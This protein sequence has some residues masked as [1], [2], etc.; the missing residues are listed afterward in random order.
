MFTVIYNQLINLKYIFMLITSQLK[1]AWD[2]LLEQSFYSNK[3]HFPE[4]FSDGKLED[5]V[6]YYKKKPGSCSADDDDENQE[7]SIC[8]C[9]ME[10]G[11]EV[12][13]LKCDHIFHRVCLDRWIG[14]GR[15]TCPLCRGRLG[16]PPASE[17]VINRDLLFFNFCCI[18]NPRDRENWWL[19]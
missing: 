11:D 7:C 12:R 13:E 4:I 16:L 6:K 9:R 18:N 17:L 1:W 15:L 10:V 3:I 19:R 14:Q 2:Y 5:H 8:L